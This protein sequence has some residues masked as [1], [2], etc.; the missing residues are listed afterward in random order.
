M[1]ARK[2]FHVVRQMSF[3]EWPTEELLTTCLMFTSGCVGPRHCTCLTFAVMRF[4]MA[5]L[6]HDVAFLSFGFVLSS[7]CCDFDEVAG[8]G[9]FKCSIDVKCDW[10]F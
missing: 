2:M 6:F 3:S 10:F 8:I 7:R 9:V 1:S 5:S 4:V